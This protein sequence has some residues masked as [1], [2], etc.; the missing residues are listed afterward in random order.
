[1]TSKT[2]AIRYA[3]ALFDV[4]LQERADLDR[5]ERELA[6]F[7]ALLTEH[8]VLKKVMLNPAVPVPRKRAAMVELTARAS[9]L[10]VVT[11]LLVLLAER[12][13]LIILP[14][15]LASF[16]DRVLSYRRVIRA[17]ITTASPLTA[18]RAETIEQQLAR[19][20]GQ[21]VTVQ[22]R[23]DASIIGGLIA[24][25]GSTVYDGSITRQLQKMRDRLAEN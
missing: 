7:D 15:L 13:R 2:A 1:M 22:T 24:R 11:K 21:T 20:T 10:S 4:A 6:G 16:R 14:D 3:R 18:A 5:V 25:L 19:V 12:D 17:E 8:P 23:V 9:T